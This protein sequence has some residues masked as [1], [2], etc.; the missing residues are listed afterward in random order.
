MLVTYLEIDSKNKNGNIMIV[1]NNAKI[2]ILLIGSC[3][4][5][6]YLNYFL[7][8]E[9]FGKKYNYVCILVFLPTMIELSMNIMGND[10]M[11]Q[12]I[13]NSGIL[14]REYIIN[15]NYFNTVRTQECNIYKIKDSFEYD[16]LL[17]NY[18]VVIYARDIMMYDEDMKTT[19]NSYIN[20]DVSLDSL[21]EKMQLKH[22]KE[23]EKYYNIISKTDVPELKVFVQNN[24]YNKRIGCTLNHP[25]NALSLE[26]YRLILKNKFNKEIPASVI[27]VNSKIE[28]L[29]SDAYKSRYTYYDRTILNIMLDEVMY[30]KCLSDRYILSNDLFFKP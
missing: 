2:N 12:I 4:I 19:F 10:R 13:R 14:I 11:K 29:N 21:S 27:D 1:D 20:N 18:D 17:P 25:T 5:T 22:K 23:L 16:V 15:Y 24:V 26:V 30:D 3:R 9:N 8:D 6:A 7:N 28:F